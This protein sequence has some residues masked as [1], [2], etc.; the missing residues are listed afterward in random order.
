M[1]YLKKDDCFDNVFIAGNIDGKRI[2]IYNQDNKIAI[3]PL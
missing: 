3:G 1:I 2:N